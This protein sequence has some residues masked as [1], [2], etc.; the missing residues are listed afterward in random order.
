MMI[1]IMTKKTGKIKGIHYNMSDKIFDP[2]LERMGRFFTERMPEGEC[3]FETFME[4][5]EW[6]FSIYGRSG[7]AFSRALGE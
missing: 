7:Q 2:G 5:P 6:A 4:R 3:T 1:E